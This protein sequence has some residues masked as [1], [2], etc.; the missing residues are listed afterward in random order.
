[1]PFRILVILNTQAVSVSALLLL[2]LLPI[3]APIAAPIATSP[4][5]LPPDSV[6]LRLIR[7]RVESGRNPGIVVGLLDDGGARVVAYGS[8]GVSGLPL[9][10]RTIFEIGSITK[11][12][13]T[14]LLADMVASGEVRLDE[15]VAAL[16]P[17]SVR[18]PTFQGHQITLLELATHT[19][20]LPRIPTNLH[21]R[22]PEDPW[23]DYT[24]SDLYQFLNS[25][26][27]TRAPGT[28]VEYSNIGSGL[29]GY[30]LALRGGK[31]YEALLRERILDPLGMK[32][33]RVTL[34]PAQEARLAQGHD[35]SGKAVEH[36]HIPTIPGA[37][38]LRSDVDDLFRYLSAHLGLSGGGLIPI[39]ARTH[40]T[41]TRL[42][43]TLAVALG[44]LVDQSDPTNPLWYHDGE[45]GGFHSFAAFDP[46]DRRTVVILSNGT[47]SI[48]DI[49]FRILELGAA[50]GELRQQ[51]LEQEAE[52]ASREPARLSGEARSSSAVEPI[53]LST[54]HPRRLLPG[55]GPAQEEGERD[56]EGEEEP[57]QLED[58][59]IRQD[60]GLL[61]NHP[62]QRR[63]PLSPR[64][65]RVHAGL[66]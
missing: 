46:A 36:W 17:D 20:G 47:N 1:V 43:D 53:G 8:S 2:L 60:R 4:R 30:A 39:F 11:T 45:T 40:Q 5:Q 27:L 31:P 44:W 26:E 33:T 62:I 49:G 52:R 7:E 22:D 56:R 48:N 21:A 18:V 38:A 28:K 41:Y 13:T 10:G 29:L 3:A 42:D 55:G 6:V 54:L 35:E 58:M 64:R 12:F 34:S 24:V 9:D 61:E 66:H 63:E 65:H 19:S 50:S 25:Y 23:A 16:L 37:G 15:P 57:H 51:R 14:S 59:V 32:D